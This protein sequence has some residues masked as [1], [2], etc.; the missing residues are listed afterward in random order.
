[1]LSVSLNR[2]YQ[3]YARIS[4]FARQA[5]FT[6]PD[7]FLLTVKNEF[8]PTLAPSPKS[9][10]KKANIVLGYS[11]NGKT[12]F[13][14][15]HA[16]DNDI[17]LSVDETTKVLI[18]RGL[19]TDNASINGNVIFSAFGQNINKALE[20]GR[21]VWVDGLWLNILTRLALIDAL[22]YGGYQV[23]LYSLLDEE[24]IRSRLTSRI[25]AEQKK[26]SS[27]EEKMAIKKF[28]DDFFKSEHNR[29]FVSDQR[30]LNLFS[31]CTD[32]LIDVTA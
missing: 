29:N 12:T 32:E 11:G 28:V 5:H 4:K 2:Y 1:M 25:Y 16:K 24:L 3:N 22:H 23:C 19:I 21:T 30:R 15:T 14:K 10:A 8:A 26:A 17:I 18:D 7:E 13:I 20:T 31:L 27:I 6:S 9:S